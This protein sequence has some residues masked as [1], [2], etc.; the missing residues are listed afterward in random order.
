MT[1]P[2]IVALISLFA[3]AGGGPATAADVTLR[4][5]HEMAAQDAINIAAMR[6]AE[7]TRNAP[8]ARST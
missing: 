4:V 2:I 8:A 7:R 3:I 6:F 5:T 1:K